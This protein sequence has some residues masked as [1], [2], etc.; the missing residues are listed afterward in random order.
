MIGP[1]MLF[2][3]L[4][5]AFREQF[6]KQWIAYSIWRSG[7]SEAELSYLSRIVPG[8]R[9]SVDVGANL[10]VYSRALAKLTPI[11]H[12]FE[13]NGE[14]AELLRRT[15]PPNVIVHEQAL[16]NRVGDGTLRL[17]VVN[18]QRVFGLASLED[19]VAYPDSEQE[20]VAVAKLDE[21]LDG[22]VGFIKIDVEGHEL[23]VLEG[24]SSLIKRC[25]PVLLIEC[26]E[27]HNPGGPAAL[28]SHLKKAGYIGRF[29]RESMICDIGE[30]SLG[31]DQGGKPGTPYIYNFFFFPDVDHLERLEKRSNDPRST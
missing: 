27:R 29:L 18:G 1:R 22:D 17:P 11:V 21:V 5:L 28:F 9:Q 19:H 24:A 30:F 13:P 10:G 16:S 31:R 23:R 20:A 8:A 26:E 12:A 15:L 3:R 25:R 4:K 6:P 7:Y 14:L 2:S